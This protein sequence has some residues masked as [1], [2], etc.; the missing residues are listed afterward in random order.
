MKKI[1]IAT[2]SSLI[3]ATSAHAMNY[4]EA[5][6]Q[7]KPMVIMFKSQRCSACQAF[8]PVFDKY[9]SQFADKFNFIKE[10]IDSSKIASKFSFDY[11]PSIFIFEPKTNKTKRISY[12]CASDNKCFTKELQKY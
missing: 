3:I 12:D 9:A 1:T 5:K 4:D 11:V 6:M 2:I 10:D 7:K 8:S